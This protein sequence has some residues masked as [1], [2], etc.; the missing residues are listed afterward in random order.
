M[1]MFD[2]LKTRLGFGDKTDDADDYI[3]EDY[4]DYDDYDDYEDDFGSYDSGRSSNYDDGGSAS[5]GAYRPLTTRSA[6]ATSPRLVSLE[7]VKEST[8]VPDRLRRDPLAPDSSATTGRI[9]GGRSVI[10]ETAP[11]PSSPA[12][13]AA[14]RDGRSRSE[15]LDA[16]F[17]PT[18]SQVGGSASEAYD[19]YE[20]YSTSSQVAYSPMRSLKVLKP[21]E[22]AEV[23]SIAKAVKA[24]DVV[25]LVLRNTP[26]SLS[27]RILDFSFGVSAAL[28]AS[29]ECPADKVFAIARGTAL[30]DAEKTNLR[31]QGVL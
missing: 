30:S 11:A 23:E 17:A 31:N 26:D 3:D 25:V 6:R 29:V 5:A 8:R 13:N 2:D 12:Y 14:M 1:S 4:D 20:A 21:V 7:D 28:D 15:G 24:G 27:K 10:D 22:Y 18:A 16:L 19:P 9:V